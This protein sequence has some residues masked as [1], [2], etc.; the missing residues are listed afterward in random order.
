MTDVTQRTNEI[1]Y[2]YIKK[3][4]LM[5]KMAATLFTKSLVKRR[6]VSGGNGG[7][8][9]V[10]SAFI[11]QTCSLKTFKT[12]GRDGKVGVLQLVPEPRFH[13]DA[14]RTSEKVTND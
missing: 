7:K 3:E 1:L 6:G 13:V 8:G 11:Q 2:L 9:H 14:I 4:F 10:I 12:R 5:L